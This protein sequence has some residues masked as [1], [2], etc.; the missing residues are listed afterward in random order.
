MSGN[1]PPSPPPDERDL[2]QHPLAVTLILWIR[3][4]AGSAEC[5]A[6]GLGKWTSA[7]S[8]RLQGRLLCAHLVVSIIPLF[9]WFPRD[10][11]IFLPATQANPVLGLPSLSA[12]STGLVC[13]HWA[14]SEKP[15]LF[16]I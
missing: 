6:K 16:P 3:S 5:L 15:E 9:T 8:W 14:H 12:L 10:P 1:V 13:L 4:R 11:A 7:L 2:K